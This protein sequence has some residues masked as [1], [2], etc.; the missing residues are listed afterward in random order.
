MDDSSSIG[1][2]DEEF[3]IKKQRMIQGEIEKQ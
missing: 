2:T 1:L 3:Q